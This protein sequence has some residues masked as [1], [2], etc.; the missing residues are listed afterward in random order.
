MTNPRTPRNEDGIALLVATIFI[1]V[2]LIIIAALG[3]RVINASRQA[4]EY[5]LY[6]Q[7]FNGAQAG[8]A[9]C[10]ANLEAGLNGNVGLGT[11]A[12][13]AT[14]TSIV[15][16]NFTTNAGLLAPV[17]LRANPNVQYIAYVDNWFTDKLDNNANGAID[18][19][20]E[21]DYYTVYAL[22]RVRGVERRIEAVVKAQD[23]NVWRNAIFAGVGN[24]GGLING[25]VSIHGSVHL[26]GNALPVGGVAVDALDLSGTSLIHNN[27]AGIPAA[28]AS[29]VP[30]L[31]TRQLG[32]DTVQT[33][34]ANLRVRHGLVGVSGNSEIGGLNVAGNTYKETLDGTFV[35]DGWTGNQTT[36]DG[37]RGIPGPVYSDNGYGNLYDLGDKVPMP[38]LNS[39]WRDP[40]TGATVINPSTGVNYTHAQYFD[41]VLAQTPYTGAMTIK[42][43]QDFYYNA[44]HPTQTDPTLRAATDHYIYFN[45]T[46][47]VMYINGQ[48]EVNGDLNV[49]RGSGNDKSISYVG[50]AAILVNG[51]VTL[52]TD[53]VTQNADGS[54]N[55]S[56]PV[57]NF[58]GIMASG[59]MTVGS[60][61]QLQLMGAFYAQGTV[62]SSKQTT[63]M[64]TF[65]GNYFDMGTNVPDIYQVPAL[66]DNLPLGMIGAYPIMVYSQVSWRELPR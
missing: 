50:R 16:P 66:A 61:S 18:D 62:A 11:W 65:V 4:Q 15:L 2:A 57:N 17:A 5:E 12:P 53:M 63:T 43:N 40:V 8:Y 22:S 19:N 9:Q 45:S 33:L 29:R 64:G 38:F 3:M 21:R 55:L 48:I 31:P 1:A 24:A 10:V 7:C 30:A 47:N 58:F 56:F 25:N 28:L 26:L 41:Q 37:G 39:T 6:A 34:N 27:Y 35:Q 20:T 49:Q 36:P 51:N 44:T 46:T 23:V 42:A 54:T 14:P 60:N 13:P 32:A 52:D 59:N